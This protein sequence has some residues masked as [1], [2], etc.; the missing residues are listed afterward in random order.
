M[1]R[2]D[3]LTPEN[4]LETRFCVEAFMSLFI[5]SPHHVNVHKKKI[6]CKNKGSDWGFEGQAMGKLLGDKQLRSLEWST[7]TPGK[8]V[9]SNS[10]EIVG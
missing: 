2:I 1:G 3:I 6:K 10:L 7:K 4:D 5:L 9:T 8:A